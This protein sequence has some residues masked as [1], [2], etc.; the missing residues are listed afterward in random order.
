MKRIAKRVLPRP[1]WELLR[2][3]R[4]AVSSRVNALLLDQVKAVWRHQRTA[5]RL[6]LRDPAD[7]VTG[8]PPPLRESVRRS[9]RRVVFYP[10]LPAERAA[11]YK[12]VTLLGM[13]ISDDVSRH[14]DVYLRWEDTTFAHV[15]A[16]LQRLGK[17]ARV[18][19]IGCTDISKCHVEEVFARTFGYGSVIDPTRHQGSAVEKTIWN[20]GHSGRIVQCPLTEPAPDA[21]YQVP[22]NNLVDG[23][24]ILD[25]RVPIVGGVIPF[26]YLK[27]R[28]VAVRF[29]NANSAV[30]LAEP[31]AVFS[32]SELEDI[33]RF[34][35][36]MALDYGEIDVLRDQ[37]DGRLYVVD[38][39][40]TPF[41]PPRE[42]DSA[43]GALAMHR[44]ASTF[45]E[46]IVRWP[47][48]KRL[49]QSEF[50]HVS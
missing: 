4:K 39:N 34:A 19:N 48:L 1:V 29:S 25:L 15:D 45:D 42:M 28:P 8:S 44:L 32:D 10:R 2:R 24:T 35:E 6:V 30:D 7:R 41:G 27:R 5:R 3:G 12:I 20:A 33:S 17:H 38:V 46:R 14:A 43:Q 18:L 13:Q 26:V 11:I 49:S 9:F 47:T 23:D 22:I 36:N 16:T 37:D 50:A 21:I 40:N 31:D